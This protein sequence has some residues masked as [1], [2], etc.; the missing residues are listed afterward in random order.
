MQV[1]KTGL[2]RGGT[3]GRPP[4]RTRVHDDEKRDLLSPGESHNNRGWWLFAGQKRSFDGTIRPPDLSSPY[5]S[6]YPNN[7]PS[8]GGLS[9][10][11][12]VSV[13]T[14]GSQS[15]HN[16]TREPRSRTT[17]YPRTPSGKKKI[18]TTKHFLT[19][20]AFTTRMLKLSALLAA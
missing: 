7:N 19:S 10:P 17:T 4:S 13:R 11:H 5:H 9:D 1:P 3:K 2:N 18:K 8:A 15:V 12:R 6:L 16:P 20:S 14:T